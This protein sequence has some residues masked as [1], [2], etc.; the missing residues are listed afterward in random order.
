MDFRAVNQLTLPDNYP[1]PRIDDLLATVSSAKFLTTLDL[2]QGYHQIELTTETIPKTAFISHCGKFEYL[3]LPFGLCNAPA[4]FQRCMDAILADIDADAYI[5]DI[6]IATDTWQAHLDILKQVFTR[7]K[8]K[9][10]FL[11]LKK[12]RFSSATIDY[13]GSTIGAGSIVPQHAKVQA[14]LDYPQPT[15]RKQVKSFLGLVG[16]Y[17]QHIPAFASITAPLN[18][19]SGNTSPR[20]VKWND[21]LDFSFRQTK[22]AFVSAPLLS[23]PDLSQPYHMYSDACSTGLGAALTQIIDGQTKNIAFFSKQLTIAESHYSATKL[24]A[25]AIACACKHFAVYLYGSFTTIYSDHK[26]LQHL[27]TMVNDNK[28]LM[29]WVGILQ[30]FPH[31]I[32]Y[33][34]GKD[35][36]VA[37]SLSRAW[38]ISLPWGPSQEGGDV[39]LTS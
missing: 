29:R 35:N 6:S 19:I 20:L 30:Q 1:L 18:A 22:E 15:T 24:E 11:K 17:R 16:Y 36:I 9:N 12:C 4:H 13:L 21:S 28:R 10:I 37:D 25:Y 23:P 8:E 2:T 5:D 38:D 39:G 34:P 27:S 3:R 32:I 31:K 7:F 26:P 14:I 33:I